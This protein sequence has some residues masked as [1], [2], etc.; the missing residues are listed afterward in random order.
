MRHSV[1]IGA[2]CLAAAV[3]SLYAQAT[4]RL[5]GVV[6]D[7]SG[8]A[9]SGAAVVCRNVETGLAH[10]TF[11]TDAGVFHFPDLPIGNYEIKISRTGFKTL[12]RD[13]V[14]LLTGHTLDLQLQLTVGAVT[15]AI[16]VA[17]AA[18]LIQNATSEVQT[19]IDSRAMQDI[20][21]NGRN[22]LELVVLTPGASFT[23]VGTIVGQQDNTGVV[24]N[25]LR[26]TDNN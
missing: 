22:P 5:G 16:E 19:T 1:S 7:A 24:V 15:E 11:S 12:V 3:S 17:A 26:S 18:P 10:Q 8:A 25:G 13:S 14:E 4:G 21:L 23:A 6:Q 20:P 9:I 2:L